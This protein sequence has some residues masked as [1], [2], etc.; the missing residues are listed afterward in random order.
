M[1]ILAGDHPLRER[2]SEE[3]FSRQRKLDHNLETVQD[4]R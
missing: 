2:K 3:L 1:A 4:R